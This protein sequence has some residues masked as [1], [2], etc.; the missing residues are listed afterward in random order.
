MLADPFAL[1]S[2]EEAHGPADCVCEWFQFLVEKFPLWA[3][4]PFSFADLHGT[5]PPQT[6][7][8]RLMIRSMLDDDG[9]S[10]EFQ[11]LEPLPALVD[12]I[13]YSML[14]RHVPIIE[15]VTQGSD[16][17]PCLPDGPSRF[18][19]W[20]ASGSTS[21]PH[22]QDDFVGVSALLLELLD[23]RASARTDDE[24]KEAQTT[25][26]D[27]LEDLAPPPTRKKLVETDQVDLLEPIVAQGVSLLKVCWDVFTFDIP[28]GTR[29]MLSAHDVTTR[30]M[31]QRWA[32][33][34]MLPFL[35]CHEILALET[36]SEQQRSYK[37]EK[38]KSYPTPEQL[39]V[40]I[41]ARRLNLEALQLGRYTLSATTAY[42][43][44]DNEPNPV[45]LAS[46]SNQVV[47]PW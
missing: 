24:I 28:D 29:E 37:P 19:P 1:P 40:W 3:F 12:L 27:F 8:L 5:H 45:D 22:G 46:K 34:L 20:L 31:Q 6:Y 35:S 43:H 26:D 18:L 4:Q 25:L 17:K 44:F 32:V 23:N 2:D 15:W 42:K 30:Q 33:R 21:Q 10:S 11:H 13:R 41:L 39:A 47:T 9:K 38:G 7:P 16:E 36:E 14:H